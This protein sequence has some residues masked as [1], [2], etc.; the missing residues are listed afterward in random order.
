[1]RKRIVAPARQETAD[2]DR[3]WLSLEDLAEVFREIQ[4][5]QWNFAAQG[6]AACYSFVRR[7]SAVARHG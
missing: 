5:Q 4:H 2:A 3:A 6:T 7:A 1:M